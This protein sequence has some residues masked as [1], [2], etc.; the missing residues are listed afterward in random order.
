MRK[1]ATDKIIM[2]FMCLIFIGVVVIIVY[3][4]A[5]PDVQ[6]EDAEGADGG[7]SDTTLVDPLAAT[8]RSLAALRSLLERSR[9]R[10]TPLAGAPPP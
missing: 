4:I 2:V 5:V 7:P 3:K 9:A 8:R 1:M 6:E 10:P